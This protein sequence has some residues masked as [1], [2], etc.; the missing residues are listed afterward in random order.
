MK[1]KK[2]T[3]LMILLLLTVP[4]IFGFTTSAPAGTS[5]ES[6]V[7][8]VSEIS[9]IYD[10]TYIKDGE[11]THEQK[12]LDEE[13]R[14][15]QE[16]EAFIVA[17]LFL[18]N[19]FYNTKETQY[20][21]STE[22]FTDA[23]IEQKKKKPNMSIYFITDEINSC[24]GAFE[25]EL[26]KKLKDNG[27]TVI[28]TELNKIRDS[29]PLYSGYWRTYI[30]PFGLEG[31]GWINNPFGTNGPKVNARNLLKLLNF[32]ANHRKVLIT[33][34]GA[35]ITSAN[36]HDA[37]SYHSNI[38][39]KLNGEPIKYLLET[40][41]SVAKFSGYE[42]DVE[43]K[44]RPLE[45]REE[46]EVRIL[47]E[48]KIRNHIMSEIQQTKTGD[49][50]QMGMFYLSH[51]EVIK[52][53]KKAAERGVHV[54]LI[55]DPNKDAFGY[56]KNG[57]PNKQ[58]AEELIKKS[59]NRIQIRWYDTHGEQ[60]HSKIIAIQKGEKITFI[61]GSANFT[62]RNLDNYNLETNI[63]IT[64]PKDDAIASEFRN[65]FN[66]IWNNQ[67]GIYTVDYETYAEESLLKT[68]VYRIQEAS[69]LCTY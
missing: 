12:I 47:T 25:N 66:R 42:M 68:L 46:T 53:I 9:F 1:I 7:T 33:D 50:I 32:K 41:K 16:S 54:Q 30:K 65:Y 22:R 14:L 63:M 6:P 3:F 8:G 51:R 57:I 69:G 2:Y 31:K 28:V 13:I 45:N 19:P 11:L 55:L 29:N 62:R 56:K 4:I 58:V 49:T 59:K 67:Q 10:L 15:I 40:E 61:A 60:Y 26:F 36:P 52:S 5:Y 48:N 20:P 64:V 37:S 38:A 39:F 44:H 35:L 17:D 23:L 18:Y 34:K 24:Y 27:I 43:Y 21:K